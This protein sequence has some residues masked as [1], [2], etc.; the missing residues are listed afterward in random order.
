VKLITIT[1]IITNAPQGRTFSTDDDFAEGTPV[2]TVA[3]DNRLELS[4]ASITPPY[5]WVPNSP[6]GTVS[7]V[8]IRT[9]KEV[10]RYRTG[11]PSA[12]SGNPSRTTVDQYGNCWVA[13]RNHGTIIQIG[14]Y[15]N[16]QYLDRNGDG[17]IQ[18]SQDLDGDGNITAAEVLDW[19][20]DE[21]VLWEVV[22]IP[23]KEGSFAPGAYSGGYGG[24][25]DAGSRAIAA[26]PWG[27]VWAGNFTAKRYYFIDNSTGQI[28]RTN[29]LAAV[30]H[31]PYGAVVDAQGLLWS[32]SAGLNHVLRLDPADNSVLITNVGH[33]AYGLGLDRNNRL[34]VSGWQS[35]A[36]SRINVLTA[37]KEWT[38]PGIYESRGVA[39]TADGDVWVAN[40]GPGTVARWSNDGVLKTTIAVGNTPTGVSID[41]EGKVWVVN[42]GDGLIRRIDPDTDTVIFSKQIN[43]LAGG[44]VGHYGYSD[45]TG[46]VARNATVR[47]GQ[48]LVV[49][50]AQV[51]FTQWG[52]VTW[53]AYEP[54]GSN[55]TVRVR[56]SQDQKRWSNWEAA[57]NGTSLG[58]TPA[59]RYLQ[60]EVAMWAQVGQDLPVL[61]DL[62]VEPLPQRTA[63]LGLGL[64]AAPAAVTN[65][66]QITYTI[67]VTN[68]G[69]QDARGILVTNRLPTG[70][71]VASI[72][73][74]LGAITQTAGEVRC[75][76]G[77]LPAGSDVTLV[78]VVDVTR[79]GNLTNL[80]GVLHYEKDLVPQNN[81]ATSITPAAAIPCLPP[82]AGLVG[83]WP[84]DGTGSDLAGTNHGGLVGA[85]TFAPGRVGQAFSFD[86][87]SGWVN[88]GR[89]SPGSQWTLEAWIKP[90]SI[91]SGRRVIMGCHADCRDWSLL[92]NNGEIGLNIG[93]GG[94]VAIV[95][96]GMTAVTGVWYH[97]LGTCDGTN[98][99]LYVNG[100]LRGS[101][102]VDLNY[103]GSASSFRLGSSVCCGEYFA[104]LAD[105]PSLYNRALTSAEALA[106]DEARGSG[107]CRAAVQPRLDISPASGGGYSIWW[108]TEAVGFRLVSAPTLGGPWTTAS[109]DPVVQGTNWVVPVSVTE[110]ARFF[111]LRNP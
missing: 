99:A 111:R 72:S 66:Q 36:L 25:N 102:P 40:S 8:D 94:C 51:E 31:T 57:P 87:S 37:E 39:V 109:P 54:A 83:W 104:G 81:L 62:T 46:N 44:A 105:E 92:L 77:A 73:N 23:G 45:M 101:G 22:I 33:I 107:K 3:V 1:K 58:A 43:A 27:N 78:I 82:P 34:F 17:L 30:G 16:G 106:L 2:G 65:E 98:A 52:T 29:D 110:P 35:S 60:V 53:Q 21:C 90:S 61:Y 79:P 88:L 18:T 68:L 67:L 19:G 47:Y 103:V 5:I 95:G 89:V 10:G 20:K 86:G 91:L 70:V 55:V 24:Y 6:E 56:S 4:A 100:E 9:G 75:E 80:A 97:V 74:S 38:R 26:D 28:L 42:L 13:N 108:T 41:S 93:R 50:D 11:P 84:G 76:I 69:P 48:W 64:Q 32:A 59:G 15:E 85:V 14:L 7:K 63:D 96:S 71:T 49:H 12:G